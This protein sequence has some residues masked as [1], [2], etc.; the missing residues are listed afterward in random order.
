LSN[1]SPLSGLTFAHKQIVYKPILYS[2]FNFGKRYFSTEQKS[3]ENKAETPTPVNVNTE[4]KTDQPKEVAT[5]ESVAPV[6]RKKRVREPSVV[7]EDWTAEFVK[8]GYIVEEDETN[9]TQDLV[10]GANESKRFVYGVEKEARLTTLMAIDEYR[11]KKTKIVIR[12][13]KMARSSKKK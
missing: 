1:T 10:K 6:A 12:A 11:K 7:K 3:Q 13:K 2:P 4:Q 9:V 5:A 8:A